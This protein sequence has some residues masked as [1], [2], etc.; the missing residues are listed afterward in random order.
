MNKSEFLA[1]LNS[2]LVGLPQNEIEERISFYSEMIDDRVEEGATEEDAVA[3]IGS[4]DEIV[5]Q[6]LEDV[7]L[8]S[9]VKENVKKNKENKEK[10]EKKRRAPKALEIT[11]LI[12]GSPV[13]LPLLIAAF[14]VILLLYVALWSIVV[15]L[16][17]V[18]ASLAACGIAGIVAGAAYAILS[19]PVDG[20]LLVAAG[21]V[22]SGLAIFAF[23]GCKAAT[24]GTVKLTRKMLFAIKHLFVGKD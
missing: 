11:L 14:A 2:R 20:L 5:A 24:K 22:C 1:A 3:G 9:I 8:W 12:L 15:S 17:A 16:W 7:P 10:K 4:I 19:K 13:W 23:I 18:F 6:I 21:F